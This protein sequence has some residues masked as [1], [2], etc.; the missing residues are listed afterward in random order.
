[1]KEKRKPL[2]IL[3]GLSLNFSVFVLSNVL[4]TPVSNNHESKCETNG[5]IIMINAIDNLL[6]R[7]AALLMVR[8]DVDVWETFVEDTSRGVH[9]S[10]ARSR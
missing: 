2:Q 1:M 5:I 6:S 9:D 3:P 10:I 7:A 8:V 4:A